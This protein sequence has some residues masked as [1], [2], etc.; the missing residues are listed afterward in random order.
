MIFLNRNKF[1]KRYLPLI[2]SVVLLVAAFGTYFV[3]NQSKQAS[4]S[5][6]SSSQG[7]WNYRQKITINHKMV[8]QA[9]G[10]TTPL[11]NFPILVSLPANALTK[12]VNNGGHV[13][14]DSGYDIV[15]TSGDGKT[16]LAHEIESYASTTGAI[17]AWVKI[18]SLSSKTDTTIYMYY[19]NASESG[20]EQNATA[21]WS[22]SF[23]DVYHLASSAAPIDSTG[24]SNGTNHSTTNTTGQIGGAAAFTSTQYIDA[25]SLGTFGSQRNNPFTVSM[26]VYTITSSS[27]E[28]ILGSVD[29]NGNGQN[30]LQI[31]VNS[32][33]D[34]G[35]LAGSVRVINSSNDASPKQVAGA[36]DANSFSANSWHNISAVVTSASN[37]IVIYVDGI[38]QPVIYRTQTTPASFSNFSTNTMFVGATN[39]AGSVSGNFSGNL[40]E[41]KFSTTAR[42][43]DWIKTEYN[44]QSSPSTFETFRRGGDT[45]ERAN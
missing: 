34:G 20:N 30:Q 3:L 45:A 28:N 39:S 9:T 17:I 21:V 11:L 7:T 14:L 2:L 40:D 15:F 41:V 43:P 19:G 10:T 25:G 38:A 16:K 12:S 13:G 4:A 22:N 44:N 24:T 37:T 42:S 5:W 36:T 23:A 18:P 27:Q 8:N 32:K 29:N 26:W 31:K 1:F 35:L 33:S 6:F